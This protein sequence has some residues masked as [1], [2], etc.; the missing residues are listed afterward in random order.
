MMKAR[1]SLATT[2]DGTQEPGSFPAKVAVGPVEI[3][4]IAFVL[5]VFTATTVAIGENHPARFGAHVD[6][7][8][9]LALS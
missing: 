2:T 7:R 6:D 5:P 3:D 4:G 9:H 1:G 8:D